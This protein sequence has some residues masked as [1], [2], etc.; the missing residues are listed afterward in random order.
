M[1]RS[2]KLK[3][4]Y[5]LY[6]SGVKIKAL[7]A[8]TN[9]CIQTPIRGEDPVFKI[10][11]RKED[12]EIAERTIREMA[13]NFTQNRSS[14]H[15]ESGGQLLCKPGEITLLVPVD[16]RYVGLL[17]GPK[18]TTIKNIQQATDTYI[19]TPSRVTDP[20]IR[21][22][23]FK[24]RGY[25]EN[26][27]AAREM[28]YNHVHIRTQ[29]GMDFTLKDAGA[30]TS[31]NLRE[32]RNVVSAKYFPSRISSEQLVQNFGFKAISHEDKENC[33][34]LRDLPST[35]SPPPSWS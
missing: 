9:T 32:A 8:Q 1:T 21:M 34:S 3:F 31:V 24:V 6:C 22:A 28:M 4:V 26:V 2:Y 7:R 13:E 15:S 35:S 11:G 12:V 25:R 20:R 30:N 29:K 27:E 16:A 18:G 33:S 19:W 23:D 5:F 14:R 10:R 17:V